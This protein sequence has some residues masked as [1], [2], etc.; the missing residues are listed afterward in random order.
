MWK[1]YAGV[2][3][4]ASG[5]GGMSAIASP[6]GGAVGTGPGGFEPSVLWMLGLVIGEIVAVGFLSRHL[7]K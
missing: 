7:L 3:A 2:N 5:G 1:T 6:A 4:Q